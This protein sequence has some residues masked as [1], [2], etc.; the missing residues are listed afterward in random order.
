MFEDFL[1]VFAGTK[2]ENDAKNV[3]NHYV[4][5]R[6]QAIA[7]SLEA[8]MFRIL[9]SHLDENR[10]IEFLPFLG[11]LTTSDEFSEDQHK[12][13]RNFVSKILLEKFQ[14][15]RESRI[16]T[17]NGIRR[18]TTYYRFDEKILKI[19]SEKYHVNDL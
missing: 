1:S 4:D 6:Q 16:K 9:I 15:V 19:L 17:I 14:A 11:V 5:Q 7:D 10:E 13:T 3:V 12:I 2:H 18:Q 8:R